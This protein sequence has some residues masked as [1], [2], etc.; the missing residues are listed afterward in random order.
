VTQS[1]QFGIQSGDV[2][3][4]L[5]AVMH[6]KNAVV[7]QL[8]ESL[9]KLLSAGR[10]RI[11]KGTAEIIDPST[12]R[13]L[14]TGETLPADRV[15][16]ASGSRPRALNIPGLEGPGIWDSKDVLEMRRVPR[17]VAV[18]G[19]G[20]IGVEFAQ[21]LSRLGARVTIIEV[22]DRLVPGVD[23][24]IARALRQAFEAEEI[25]V[26]T[27]ARVRGIVH[28]RGSKTVEFEAD[29]R[30]MKRSVST[31]LVSV[32]REPDLTRLD[33]DRLGVAVEDAAIRVDER[34]ETSVPGI[35][36]VGDVTGGIMLAHVA[37]AEGECA[38]KNAVGEEAV[39]RYEAI[40]S[41]IYTSP[42][43]ASVGLVEEEA[44]GKFDIEVGRFS[45]HGSGK[46]LVLNDTFGMVKIVSDRKTGRVL[47][48][49]IIGP[50]A[51]DMI[52]EAVLGMSMGMT[53]R[54]LARAIRPH[55]S[56]SEAIM[57]SALTLCGGAIHMP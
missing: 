52:G 55:P 25:E 6:R 50:H 40:P 27:G 44:A 54:E 19:G 17:R 10:I 35:Y 38:A 23:R 37:M 45:F 4:D 22:L 34:M 36:A 15:L 9:G 14:E 33:T 13:I 21:I 43:V 7:M 47:G 41:C 48:V 31:V 57:E 12:V 11:V 39:M 26:F 5:K 28:R 2:R 51:T 46:A 42:E 32:G 53:V 30:P 18:I 16:I 20:V 8:R 3:I 1:H 56:L 49:H 29:G 24:E